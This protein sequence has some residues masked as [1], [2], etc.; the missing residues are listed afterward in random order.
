MT[1]FVKHGP[2]EAIFRVCVSHRCFSQLKGAYFKYSIIT[3]RQKRCVRVTQVV[4]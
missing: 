3:E 2:H 4:I 1:S